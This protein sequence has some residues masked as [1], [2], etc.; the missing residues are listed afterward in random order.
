L[1][2]VYSEREGKN[3]KLY[4]HWSDLRWFEHGKRYCWG[5]THN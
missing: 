3:R 1:S 4:V 2:S 5:N